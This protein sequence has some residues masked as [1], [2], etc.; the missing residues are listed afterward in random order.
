MPLAEP[1]V[2]DESQ[3]MRQAIVLLDQAKHAMSAD[4]LQ[5]AISLLEE[6]CWA[7]AGIQAAHR[8]MQ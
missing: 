1:L 6:E 7:A 4:F 2:D 8:A 3:L 5:H